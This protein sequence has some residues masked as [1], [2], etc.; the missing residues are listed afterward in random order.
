MH[1]AAH[2]AQRWQ[3]RSA[4]LIGA[5][6]LTTS[7]TN[8]TSRP[9]AQPAAPVSPTVGLSPSPTI[10]PSPVPTPSP[11][12]L[13]TGLQIN[14][15]DPV[16]VARGYVLTC[17]HYRFD[18]PAGWVAALTAPAYTTAAFAAASRPSAQ[19][20]RRVQISQDISSAT[21]N[22]ATIDEEAP[23]TATSVEVL[24]DFT[25]TLTYRG[26][27]SGQPLHQMWL[28]RETLTSTGQWRVD[29]VPASN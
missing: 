29:G 11:S 28:L 20:L 5:L 8:H 12:A 10:A 21:I 18:D 9:A 6:L 26:A 3:A 24:V 7:C 23:H 19:A 25:N 2:P 13:P 1:P 22:S 15:Q 14:Y 17:Q 16:A 4:G 27:G